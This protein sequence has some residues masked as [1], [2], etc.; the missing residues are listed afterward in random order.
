M[1]GPTPGA[2]LRAP[3]IFTPAFAALW[4]ATAAVI[5]GTQLLTASLPLYAVRLGASDAVV[6]LMAGAIAAVS[7]VARPM[8]GIWLDR[9]GVVAAFLTGIALVGAAALGYWAVASVA[10]VLL[11]RA[12]T[13][14]AI[15]MHNTAGQ[16]LAVTLAPEGRVAETVS[17]YSL[18]GPVSQLVAPPIGVALAAAL[19]YPALFVVCA[20]VSLAALLVG[21]AIRVPPARAATRRRALWLNRRVLLPGVWMLTLM[22]PFGANVGLLAVHASRRG[23]ANPGVVFTAMAAGLLLALLTLARRTDRG[24]PAAFIVPGLVLGAL[25]MWLTALASGSV[26]VV[27]GLLGGVSLGVA[28]PVLYAVSAAL[29]PAGERG[30]ALATMG[31]FLE[32]GIGLGAIGGGLA[33]RAWGLGTMFALAG[34]APALGALLAFRFRGRDL[35]LGR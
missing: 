21:R 9:G 25:A 5:F 12:L 10:G 6:G 11:F 33:G 23:L 32:L 24:R 29:V 7:L 35:A 30:S 31:V 34:A 8:V 16:L 18:T 17:L 28:Q 13:G 19:G 20:G 27:A 26:L 3:G 4:A 2:A 1:P 15:A 22:V 14:L